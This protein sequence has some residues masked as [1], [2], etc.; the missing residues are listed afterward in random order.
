MVPDVAVRASN[1]L[2]CGYFNVPS[3]R[4]DPTAALLRRVKDEGGRTLLD[5]GWDHD[6]WPEATREEAGLLLPSVDVFLP[7]E[8][9]A[10]VLTGEPDPLPSA[11]ALGR[12]SGG[13][14][15]RQA[16]CGG[17]PCRGPAGGTH[18]V[19]APSVDVVD[20]TGA[21]DAF[22]AGLMQALGAGEA[23]PEAPGAAVLLASAVVSRPSGDRYPPSGRL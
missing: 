21:G 4:G 16:R 1:V 20:T 6:G 19:G 10:E 14:G 13:L 17:V 9:E 11:T 12:L 7:N 8:V 2:L 22:N 18:R 15:R 5:T 3:M 23:W